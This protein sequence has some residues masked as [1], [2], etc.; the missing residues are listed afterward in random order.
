[1]ILKE[2]FHDKRKGSSLAVLLGT[3]LL[4]SFPFALLSINTKILNP[5]SL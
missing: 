4:V 5:S 2:S 1:M 3:Y